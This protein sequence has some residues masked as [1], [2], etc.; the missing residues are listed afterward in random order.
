MK[1]FISDDHWDING[2][3]EQVKTLEPRMSKR[4]F[5]FFSLHSFHDAKVESFSIINTRNSRTIKYPTRIEALLTQGN[6]ST[7]KIIWDKVIG[8]RFDYLAKENLNWIGLDDWTYDELTLNDD[9]SLNH[10][11]QLS[12]GTSIYINFQRID[13]RRIQR[14]ST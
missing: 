3:W 11:I 12:S 5:K 7:Y 1:Y 14:S 2:Y 6:R 13:Y 8:I 10:E 4:A 9:N